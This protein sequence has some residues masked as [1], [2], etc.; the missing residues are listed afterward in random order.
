MLGDGENGTFGKADCTTS[1]SL[2]F[3]SQLCDS[4]R[5]VSLQLYRSH[6]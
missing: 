5:D 6:I 4:R 2:Y 1:I 3:V